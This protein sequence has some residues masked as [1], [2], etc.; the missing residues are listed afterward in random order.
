MTCDRTAICPATHPAAVPRIHRE[1]ENVDQ[2]TRPTDRPVS[3][4][5][6]FLSM[7]R[8]SS[9]IIHS[10]YLLTIMNNDWPP[11]SVP[12]KGITHSVRGS[13]TTRRTGR[14]WTRFFSA[15]VC[16]LHNGGLYQDGS[17]LRLVGG[18]EA[19]AVAVV[20]RQAS[21]QVSSARLRPRLE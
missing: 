16:R 13:V 20:G 3:N 9:F 5:F 1:Y 8:S 10:S 2:T 18:K 19:V 15:L 17:V 21:K 7:P 14:K 4:L 11:D 12:S 6:S